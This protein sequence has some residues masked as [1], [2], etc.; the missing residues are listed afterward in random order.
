MDKKSILLVEDNLVIGLA[1]KALLENFNYSVLT[2]SSGEEAIK[3]SNS[4]ERLDLILMDID[5]GPGI[6][7]I[8]ASKQIL[9]DKLYPIVFL[10]SRT[11]EDYV[12][13]MKEVSRYGIVSKNS[14]SLFLKSSIEMA[15]ELFD[16]NSELLANKERTHTL[17]N[18]LEVGVVAH[19][20]D[21][22]II[23]CN[24][25]ASQLLGLSH[26]Q[27]TGRTAIDPYWRFIDSNR[28][29]IP[30]ENYPVNK[31]LRTGAPIKNDIVGVIKDETNKATWLNVN[32][33][34]IIKDGNITEVIISFL[35]IK[36][37]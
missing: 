9:R 37:P 17:I 11:E 27:M 6:D 14:G 32:G 4:Q 10:T 24:D 8:E 2:A 19:T 26:D 13:R 1:N 31:V 28:N 34:P 25:R 29:A 23:E 15:F 16:V 20:A 22:T 35:E 7:G 36:E 12:R 21:T 18:H 30:L 3:I 5:L 33:V